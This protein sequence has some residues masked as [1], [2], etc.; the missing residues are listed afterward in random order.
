MREPPVSVTEAVSGDSAR[1]GEPARVVVLGAG[2]TGL[3][4]AG[5][6]E[7]AGH[8]VTVLEKSRGAGGRMATRRRDALQFDH[9]APSF[10]AEDPAFVEAVAGWRRAGLLDHWRPRLGVV[11]ELQC[12]PAPP[13][14]PARFVA[15]PGM[16]GL[17]RGLAAALRD[18]RFQWRATAL[19]RA[20]GEWV[21]R[22]S[23]GEAGKASEFR[24]H[25]LVTTLPAPQSAAL[26]DGA[27]ALPAAL[28]TPLQPCWAV[29]AELD[30][31]VFDHVDAAW[32]T[33]GELAWLAREASKP[34]RPDAEAW[35]LLATPAW[36]ARHLESSAESVCDALLGAARELPGAGAF[37]VRRAT[38]HRWRYAQVAGGSGPGVIWRE[39]DRLAVAGDWCLG[40]GVESA[41]RAGVEVAERIIAG[42]GGGGGAIGGTAAR[43]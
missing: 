13:G 14:G 23:A 10:I 6:L 29:M 20:D 11:D 40:G 24:A 2:L 4:A 7:A 38:A 27:C 26:L 22:G 43:A 34:G 25:T 35:T 8:E 36:A 9:G 31:P 16:S 21:V 12:A 30:A 3:V 28:D 37:T 1:R 18:C 17:C 19:A 42:R 15:V 41:W 5:R 39:A 32:V 33:V